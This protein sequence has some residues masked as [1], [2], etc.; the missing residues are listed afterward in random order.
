MSLVLA[1]GGRFSLGFLREIYGTGVGWIGALITAS[2]LLIVII[3]IMKIDWEGVV[4]RHLAK[5]M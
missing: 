3:A 1:Y 4:E 2:V 5:A